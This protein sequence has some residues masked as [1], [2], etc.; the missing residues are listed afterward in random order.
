M[1]R[2]MLLAR[3]Y[4][5]KC[6][7]VL[8]PTAGSLGITVLEMQIFRSQPQTC[9]M[10]FC[11][12]NNPQVIHKHIKVAYLSFSDFSL[13]LPL[14]HWLGPSWK[15]CVLSSKDEGDLE[16]TAD[17]CQVTKHLGSQSF[18]KGRAKWHSPCLLQSQSVFFFF[19]SANLWIH[20]KRK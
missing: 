2:C 16:L 6:G 19:K 7:S 10:G 14:S 4:S 9:W 1:T 13:D 20:A 18:L 11:Y 12:L 3:S 5:R 15:E 17:D 8:L